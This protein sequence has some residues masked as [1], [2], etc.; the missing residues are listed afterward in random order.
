[1]DESTDEA[2]AR[3]FLQGT[4][5]PAQFHHRDHLRL[6]WYLVRQYDR[7]EAARLIATSIRTFA[8]RHGQAAKYHETLTQFWVRL[9]AYLVEQHPDITSFETFLATFPHLLDKS[10][11]YRHWRRETMESVTARARWVEPD[12]L[13]LPAGG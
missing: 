2:F 5:S 7:E 9:V 10:L 1:M 13:A 12:V 6:T 8:T 3:A 4:V 11:P